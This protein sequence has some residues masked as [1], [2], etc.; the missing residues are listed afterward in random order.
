MSNDKVVFILRVLKNIISKFVDSFLVLYF[1]TVSERN[2][3]PLGIYKL[4][5]VITIYA[6]IFLVRNYTKS[7]N[8][9]NLMRIGII[10]DFVYF[11][12]I[13]LLKDKII[14]YIYLVGIL[15]GLEEGFY[16]SIY[17]ILETE[18]VSNDKRAK[19]MGIHTATE[20]ILTIMFPLLFGSL[21]YIEGFLKSLIV[22]FILILIRIIFSFIYKDNNIPD[23]NKTDIKKYIQ[24]TRNDK[25]YKQMYMISFLNGITYSDSAFAYIIIIYITKVFSNSFSLGIFTSVFSLITCIIGILF[26]KKM[27]KKSY[28]PV[29]KTSTIFTVVFLF[30][31][32]YKCNA[33]T[34]VLFYLFQTIGKNL[35]DLIADSNQFNLCNDSKIQKE[36]KTEYWL[37]NETVLVIG[38]IISSLIF[39][40]VAYVN[41]VIMMLIYPVFIIL[42][43]RSTINLQKA[44]EEET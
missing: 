7:K 14:N 41:P 3:L 8:R 42:F 2:I 30:I 22:V 19:F 35:K 39:I 4:V 29:I 16:Y 18:G 20:S 21:I 28:I 40:L 23:G 11:L 43:A 9:A 13:I 34:I 33:T 6:V 1:L 31:M 38:R 25:R 10:L 32:I 26:A 24:L 44:I 5:S 36:Y 27:K 17:N 15:Y 37:A 12:S